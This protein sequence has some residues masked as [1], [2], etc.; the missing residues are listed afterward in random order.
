MVLTK[1]KNIGRGFSSQ[2]KEPQQPALVVKAN[3]IQAK[4]LTAKDRSGK[5]DPY[6][7]LRL[8]NAKYTTKVISSNLDPIWNEEADLSISHNARAYLIEAT[9]WDRDRFTRKDYLGEFSVNLK[10][11]FESMSVAKLETHARWYPLSSFRHG[12]RSK[13][14]SGSVE[15]A[16]WLED[17]SNPEAT[18]EELRALWLAL[19]RE[20]EGQVGAAIANAPPDEPVGMRMAEDE[21]SS[22]EPFLSA[23][24]GVDEGFDDVAS[25]ASDV[26]QLEVLDS[27]LDNASELDLTQPNVKATKT[28]RRKKRRLRRA[29][30]KKPFHFKTSADGDVLGVVFLEIESAKDLPKERNLTKTGFDMDPFVITSFSKKTF[31]TRVVRHSLN[32][33]FGDKLLFQVH[34]HEAGYNLKFTIVDRDKFSGNDL[35][36]EAVMNVQELMEIGPHKDAVTGLYRLPKTA[37]VSVS[38]A[39]EKRRLLGLRRPKQ[40]QASQDEEDDEEAVDNMAPFDLPLT[41]ARK[42]FWQD[43]HKPTLQVKAKFMP[44]PALRQQFWRVMLKHFDSDESNSIS[45]IELTTMLDS[46]GA[47][48]KDSTVQSFFDRF[49]PVRSIDN[50][51]NAIDGQTLTVDQCVICLEDILNHMTAKG[52]SIANKTHS[53]SSSFVSRTSMPLPKRQSSRDTTRP[54]SPALSKSSSRPPS[55]KTSDKPPSEDTLAEVDG[56]DEYLISLTQCP[57]CQRANIDR[58]SAVDIVTHLATCASQDWRKVDHLVMG[59]FITPSQAQRKW[60]TKIISKVSYGGYKL[61]ANSAN[62]LVQDRITGQVQEE[63][64]SVYVRLGIRLLYK[65]MKSS[66][67]ES[68]RIRRMLKTMS[69]KQGIKYD[70]PSSAKDIKPFIAFHRLNM[71]EVLDPVDSFKSFNEFFYRKLKPDA[72]PCTA[73]NDPRIAVSP[74]DCRSVVFNTLTSATEIWVKG[75]QFSIARLFGDAYPEDV[76][77]FENGSFGIFRLA[78]QDYHRFHIPVDGTLGIPKTI[79]GQYYTVNPMAIRSNLDVYGENVRVLIPV[80][81][82]EFGRVMIVCIGAMMVGSTVI[83]AEPGPVS[84]TDELGYFKFG[85]STILLIFEPGRFEFDTDLVQNATASLETLLRMGSSIGHPPGVADAQPEKKDSVTMAEKEEASRQIAGSMPMPGTKGEDGVWAALKDPVEAARKA[86]EVVLPQAHHVS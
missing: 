10:H 59:D 60:Y 55:I 11:H 43:R 53:S 58:K 74:A 85:G 35:V 8:N 84:R 33:V 20:I 29:K 7:V 86:K 80:D 45:K 14:V 49:S 39:P 62:I 40:K 52:D 25:L 9:C 64:M 81:T 65:G 34:K 46:L 36:G 23:D 42:D 24:E 77:R 31:R 83:T 73:P 56:Q 75:Q 16:I 2:G 17:P 76:A 32:P 72:R 82:K 71:D 12:R 57:L 61:G 51:A 44:Y 48:L 50:D 47:T 67:M 66:R 27:D 13:T 6:L 28:S 69:I 38:D 4:D 68:N 15:V 37:A 1:L 5:S 54:A 79:E 63:R 18:P 19:T 21:D 41:L 78:P 3:I 22:D 70:S 30:S 26:S